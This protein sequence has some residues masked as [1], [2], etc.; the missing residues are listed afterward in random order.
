MTDHTQVFL[1]YRRE[2]SQY[3][4]QSIFEALIEK[5]GEGSVF[6]D[7]DT[8]PLGEDFRRH[9]EKQVAQC[10]V[11]LAVIGDDWLDVLNRRRGLR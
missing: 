1:S 6:F 2:D 11:L 4:A 7:V 3:I 5:F 8:L 10:D 9:L